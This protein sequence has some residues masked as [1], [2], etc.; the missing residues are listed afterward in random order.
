MVQHTHGNQHQPS[1][2]KLTPP[3]SWHMADPLHTNLGTMQ[4]ICSW[5]GQ[6]G[7]EVGM[8]TIWNKAERMEE[9]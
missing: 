7:D 4:H 6:Y 3:T 8:K 9:S 2:A 1:R 5:E